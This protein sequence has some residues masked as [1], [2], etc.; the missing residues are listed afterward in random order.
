M[1]NDRSGISRR[2]FFFGSLLAAAIPAGGY[3]SAASLTRLGYKSPNEKLNIA[4]I[5]AG[6]RPYQ[7]MQDCDDENIVALADVDWSRG[8]Q[9]F[10]KWP[11]AEKYKDFRQ[12]L[13][14]SGNDIDAVLIGTPDHTHAYCALACMQ[15]GKHVYLE[16]PLTRTSSEARLLG[17]AAEKYPVATQMGNQGYSHDATRVAAE[18]F[19]SGEIGEVKE[20]HAW[21]RRAVWPQGMGRI[22]APTPV[23]D[24]LDW[25]LWLGGG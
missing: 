19:W 1:A 14:K 7:V 10:S 3:G 21:M 4:G 6:G 16:K 9:G 11:K 23:P 15:S 12:M 24:T 18:I 17:K 13:D 2:Y 20:V 5:G 25:D 22:A 8:Q